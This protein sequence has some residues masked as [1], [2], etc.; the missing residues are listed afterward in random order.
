MNRPTRPEDQ[1]RSCLAIRSSLSRNPRL[2][3]SCSAVAPP[4]M[5]KPSQCQLSDCIKWLST[6]CRGSSMVTNPSTL[7]RYGEEIF[8]SPRSQRTTWRS[9]ASSTSRTVSTMLKPAFL[10]ALTER[11]LP[12]E[13]SATM[14]S[15]SSLMK[16]SSFRTAG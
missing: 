4:C 2:T 1:L 6:K 14:A 16:C 8:D 12:A 15:M 13:G 11:R 7:R 10:N 9:K 5:L 3:M